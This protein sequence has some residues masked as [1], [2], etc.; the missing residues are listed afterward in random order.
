MSDD[1]TQKPHEPK[2]HK[3]S[4]GPKKKL[5]HERSEAMGKLRHENYLKEKKKSAAEEAK[6]HKPKK[7]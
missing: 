3:K 1:K 4:H 2:S 5:D 6:Q 7:K